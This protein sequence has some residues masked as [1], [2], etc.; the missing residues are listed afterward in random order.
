MKSYHTLRFLM[1]AMIVA[2]P[3]AAQQGGVVFDELQDPNLEAFARVGST[4]LTERQAV[5]LAS[6]VEPIGLFDSLPAPMMPYGLPGVAILD[7]DMDGDLDLYT[8]NGAGGSNALFSNQL[9]ETGVV[10][11]IDRA[12]EA[13]VEAT[14]QDSFGTCFGDLDNDGDHDLLVLG[15]NEPNRLFRN[16]GDGTFTLMGASGLGGG[17]LSSTSCSMADFDADGLLDV[18]VANSFDQ[19]D[20]FAIIVEPYN[21]NQH[22]QLFYNEGG[23]LFSDASLSSGLTENGGFYAGRAGITWTVGTADVDVDGDVDVVF[24]DDQGGIPPARLCAL[25]PPDSP[26][27]CLDRS[28]IHVFLNDGTG[29]FVDE[30]MLDGPNVASEWMGVSFGDLNCDGAMDFFA[31]SF[32]D[33]DNPTFG[34]P[35]VG[36]SASRWLLGNGDGT[37]RDEGVGSLNA[38]PFGWGNAIFDYDNDGDLDVLYHGG[39][40]AFTISLRDNP[41]AILQNQGCSGTFEADTDALT[42]DHSRRNVRGLAIG[43]FDRNGFADVA[44]VSNFTLSPATPLLPVPVA[45]GSPFDASAFFAP[46]MAPVTPPGEPP[47]FQWLG[48]DP[49]NGNVKVELND[50]GNGN[51]SFTVRA[52][53]SIGDVAGATVNRDGIGA[54][55]TATPRHG[56]PVMRPVVG[57]S[58]HS[59]QHSLEKVFGLGSATRGRLDVLWPGGTRNRLYGVGAGETV[60]MPEIPCSFDTPQSFVDYLDCVVPA[61]HD[62]RDADVIGW[63]EAQ[64]LFVSAVIARFED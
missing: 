46:L 15:R 24:M 49:E 4:S 54:V 12:A 29:T 48:V 56:Q 28:L 59:S 31:T 64:R 45:Y 3:L 39:L 41:G 37:F 27:P 35:Y 23:L 63:A 36:G 11:F 20:S 47:L 19:D 2:G 17:N 8:T 16:Q 14:D 58:S 33:Y 44:T 34:V 32:G 7:Y 10:G 43:D 55:L 6:L 57:G 52:R 38:T 9:I 40:D 22:N 30:P 51:H 18:V 25:L 50:G 62:L 21:L 53:G 13:G 26:Q 42:V 60:V 5:N 61:L 1:F